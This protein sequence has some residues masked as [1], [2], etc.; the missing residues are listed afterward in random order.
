MSKPTIV[1]K[2]FEKQF[3]DYLSKLIYATFKDIENN[4][5]GEL[6]HSKFTYQSYDNLMKDKKE[7]GDSLRNR[8]TITVEVRQ[9]LTIMFGKMIEEIGMICLTDKDGP[10]EIIEKLKEENGSECYSAFMFE[11]YP[12][13]GNM[14]GE[15]LES[16]FDQTKWFQNK[17][18]GCLSDYA[19]KPIIIANVY[20]LFDNFMKSLA[21][22]FGKMLWYMET[23][24][25]N[26]L[27]LGQI[28]ALGMDQI[29]LDELESGLR[30]KVVRGRKSKNTSKSSASKNSSEISSKAK[31]G[32]EE[33][34]E[35]QEKIKVD[36]GSAKSA[37][38]KDK[39]R[40]DP[41]DE[42][43]DEEFDEEELSE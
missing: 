11:I 1:A 14:F 33:T 6:K 43:F 18:S 7:Q 28:S 3:N 15:V 10:E 24:L 22:I 36:I 4:W 2:N 42:E 20:K 19:S 41:S 37:N 30:A 21:W 27:F 23:T 8:F 9:Y 12:K 16:A 5:N 40:D 35:L 25:S 17:L 31:S 26:K 39:D 38:E 29:M 32:T 34:L 13:F